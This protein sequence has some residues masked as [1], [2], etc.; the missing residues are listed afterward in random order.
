VRAG[1]RI[2]QDGAHHAFLGQ[3]RHDYYERERQQA[4]TEEETV[5]H[6]SPKEIGA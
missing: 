6:N 3:R 4:N 1:W 5:L 2:E